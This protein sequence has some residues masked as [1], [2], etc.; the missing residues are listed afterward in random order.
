MDPRIVPPYFK[1][2]TET[3]QRSTPGPLIFDSEVKKMA[4]YLVVVA[5]EV[6]K[7]NA[8]FAI[9]KEA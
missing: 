6:D 3:D 2:L 1:Q 8:L 4:T 9:A 5:T 7:H